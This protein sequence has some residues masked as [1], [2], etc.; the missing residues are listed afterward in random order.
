MWQPLSKFRI[1]ER[2][3]KWK[4]PPT[5]R[6]QGGGGVYCYWQVCG[7][8]FRILIPSQSKKLTFL[9][10]IKLNTVKKERKVEI[11]AVSAASQS[12]GGYSTSLMLGKYCKISLK[13]LN[14]TWGIIPIYGIV[15]LPF[16]AVFRLRGG[17][18]WSQIIQACS[19][20]VLISR[21][22]PVC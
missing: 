11:D 15:L 9:Q 8:R 1:L 10:L 20:R 6:L 12:C 4:S 16:K 3:F 5:E 13:V 21:N 7:S 14:A 19:V 2:K 22:V 18:L 17:L